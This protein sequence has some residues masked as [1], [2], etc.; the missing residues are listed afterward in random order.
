MTY[1]DTGKVSP[2]TQS[3]IEQE[4]RT[5]LR[6]RA[7]PP[8]L[9]HFTV[10]RTSHTSYIQFT[11]RWIECLLSC[12]IH[13]SNLYWWKYTKGLKYSQVFSV[14][15]ILNLCLS[16]LAGDWHAQVVWLKLVVLSFL[17]Y[18]LTLLLY[19]VRIC[20]FPIQFTGKVWLQIV[21]EQ[22]WMFYVT[23]TFHNSHS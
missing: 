10:L 3:A 2:E 11:R 12:L 13:S 23:L 8:P 5:L 18:A 14:A 4:V 15:A 1:T 21:L 16:K 7:S 6:V 17:I 19:L 20:I 9:S 22:M